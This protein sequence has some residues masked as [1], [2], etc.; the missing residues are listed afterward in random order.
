MKIKG[1]EQGFAT[2]PV[3]AD[4]D[5]FLAGLDA[6]EEGQRLAAAEGK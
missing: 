4:A 5:N 3:W 1:G 6:A 2:K